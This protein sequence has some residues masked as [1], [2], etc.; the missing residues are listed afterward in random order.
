MNPNS[1]D[2]TMETLLI[3]IACCL[4]VY[5]GLRFSIW[6]D[7]TYRIRDSLMSEL[8]IFEYFI[9]KCEVSTRNRDIII[10]RLER[11]K[12]TELYRRHPG[13]RDNVRRLENIYREK[14]KQW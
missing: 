8:Y 6:Y 5:V 1:G 10:S 3:I 2:F 11:E 7:T 12:D 14:F 13:Y 9:K 4:A